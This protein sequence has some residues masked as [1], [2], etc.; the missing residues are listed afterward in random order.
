MQV[1]SGELVSQFLFADDPDND[2]ITFRLVNNPRFGT[3]EIKRDAQG[4]W[5][6]YYR[7]VN[8]YVGPDRITFIAIDPFGKESQVATASINVVS[9][10]SAPSALQAGDAASGGDS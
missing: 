5:R 6:V 8:G 7:S 9:V 2:A 3:G 1:A 4:K 10:T